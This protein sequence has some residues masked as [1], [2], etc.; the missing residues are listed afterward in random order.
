MKMNSNT[1]MILDILGDVLP[2]EPVIKQTAPEQSAPEQ[3]L[4]GFIE[5]DDEGDHGG[6]YAGAMC[7]GPELLNQTDL[8]EG[9]GVDGSG[10]FT[11]GKLVYYGGN[12]GRQ[13]LGNM[14]NIHVTRSGGT[15]TI[16]GLI[17]AE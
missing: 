11:A 3:E 2:T 5:G 7:L 9:F 14:E 10:D 13:Y 17:R 12:K 6:T 1:D 16:T 4:G 15:L 8:G